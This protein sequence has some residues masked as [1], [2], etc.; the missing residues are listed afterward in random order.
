M[1]MIFAIGF[2]Q[3]DLPSSAPLL[4]S[5][6]ASAALFLTAAEAAGIA[7]KIEHALVTIGIYI[8]AAVLLFAGLTWLLWTKLPFLGWTRIAI[9]VPPLVLY[10]LLMRE[11]I[12]AYIEGKKW[13]L[14][15]VKSGH[16]EPRA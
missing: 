12:R 2:F 5:L 16:S 13:G 6:L 10:F 7:E 1:T 11:A 3:N 8:F 15:Q 4:V 9:V 14:A